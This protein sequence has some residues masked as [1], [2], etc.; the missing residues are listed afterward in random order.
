VPN[1]W[2]LYDPLQE[3]T[4]QGCFRADGSSDEWFLIDNSAFKLSPTYPAKFV[5]PLHLTKVRVR[6]GRW[7]GGRGRG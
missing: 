3:F 1:G 5:M 4:R 6:V 2:L 7:G